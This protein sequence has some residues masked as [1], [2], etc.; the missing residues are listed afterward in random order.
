MKIDLN[1]HSEYGNFKL[2]P[3][4]GMKL[5]SFID[6]DS[7][8]LI[9]SESP[10]DTSNLP[11]QHGI[12]QIP[13]TQFVVNTNSRKILSPKEWRTH[14][15]YEIIETTTS[16]GK[17]KEIVQ[18]IHEPDNNTDSIVYSLLNLETNEFIYK[19]GS[20]VA[21]QDKPREN[22]VKRYHES[23]ENR[24]KYLKSLEL[25]NYPIN[26]HNQYLNELI[27]GD[28]I[29]QYFNDKD[30]FELNFTKSKFV[31]LKSSKP[32]RREEWE[33]IDYEKV[34]SFNNLIDFWKY[35][36]KPNQ[37]IFNFNKKN[38]WY[39]IYTLRTKSRA[40]EKFI[41]QEHNNL[42]RNKIIPYKRYQD[43]NNWMNINY[44]Q[45]LERNVFWQFCSNCRERVFYN[46]RY[47]NHACRKCVDEIR[48]S[49][50]S[51]LDYRD[52]RWCR[53]TGQ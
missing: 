17:L 12:V 6:Y 37:S 2:I 34:K 32:K 10:I 7:K 13:S 11:S 40:I 18:R 14:F 49:N 22:S 31:L 29:I 16:D 30:V 24:K 4:D 42:V 1:Q 38:N 48:D 35:L 47:P 20:S 44:N 8:L 26:K 27:E 52:M 41:I 46:P 51:K 15:N 43:L 33:S 53:K 28:S 39:S 21:F 5:Y 19:D 36:T 23:I 25:G 9:V 3:D 50:G 45:E